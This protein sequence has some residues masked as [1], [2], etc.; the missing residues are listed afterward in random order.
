MSAADGQ[1]APEN[2]GSVVKY[3]PPAAALDLTAGAP[4]GSTKAKPLTVWTPAQFLSHIPDTSAILLGDGLVERGS[5]TSLVGIGG[6]GKTRITLWLC[7]CQILG[8]EWCGLPTRGEPQNVLYLS[9]ENGLRRWKTDLQRM[10]SVLTESERAKVEKHLRIM[11]LTAEEDGDLDLGND[12]SVVRIGATLREFR[13]GLVI[14]DPF[15]DMVDGD[16]NKTADL[17]TTLRK[18]R[19]TVRANAPAAAGIIVHHAR[20]GAV[21]IVQ[22]GDN[23][24]AGNFGRGSKALYSFVRCEIQLAPGSRD[25]DTLLLLACGKNNNGEKFK[26]RGIVFNPETFAYAVDPTFDLATWRADVSGTRGNK[27]ASIAD[28]VE[29]VRSLGGTGGNTIKAGKICELVHEDTAACA[30]TIK[31]RIKEAVKEGYLRAAVTPR[32]A[33]A[34]GPKPLPK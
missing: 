17:V 21:N 20:T 27:T 26:P 33:Y 6:L 11:A 2:A 31:T 25:D 9:T 19:Q 4:D 30:R 5:W 10:L 13:P 32:G 3:H 7:I 12:L 23:F 1:P 8:R 15:A 28:V 14:F 16:E 18:L 22:A 29:A 34:L 24:S